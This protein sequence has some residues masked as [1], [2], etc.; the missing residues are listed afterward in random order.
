MQ[1]KIGMGW[2]GNMNEMSGRNAKSN[3]VAS[4]IPKKKC[5]RDAR[6]PFR[7]PSQLTFGLALVVW[8]GVSSKVARI[9]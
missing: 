6:M 4:H 8:S 5:G 7:L 3:R 1:V 9:R 2:D